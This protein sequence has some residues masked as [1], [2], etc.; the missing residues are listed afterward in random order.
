VSAAHHVDSLE[1][2][3]C[4]TT[5]LNA[6]PMPE[7]YRVTVDAP[8]AAWL[9]LLA[10]LIRTWSIVIETV[11]LAT[12][13]LQPVTATPTLP[14][15]PPPTSDRI[16]VSDTQADVQRSVYPVLPATEYTA[17]PMLM[18][19]MVTL[20]EPV[21]PMLAPATTLVVIGS[22]ERAPL[23]LA[24]LKPAVICTFLLPIPPRAVRQTRHVSD[25]QLVP[26]QAVSWPSRPLA[27]K[28]A[29]PM[30]AP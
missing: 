30:L 18:P 19:C 29:T 13:A 2:D 3:P 25:C 6:S 14:V 5:A 27:V 11:R 24:S 20:T 21:A 9:A 8:V 15:E 23:M 16:D 28:L 26:S 7:P 22:I 10:R 12:A 4:A 1:V 17:S